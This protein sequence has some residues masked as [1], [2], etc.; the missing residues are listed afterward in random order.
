M[1]DSCQI[2]LGSEIAVILLRTMSGS[3]CGSPEILEDEVLP[4]KLFKE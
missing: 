3:T 4:N 2:Y 1:S